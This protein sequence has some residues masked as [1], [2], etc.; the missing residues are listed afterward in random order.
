V[1]PLLAK[2]PNRTDYLRQWIDT[3]SNMA[4]VIVRKGDANRA[5][6]MLRGLVP[7]SR[8]LATLCPRDAECILTESV[9]YSELIDALETTD[10]KAA[11]E[12]ARLQTQADE[13]ADQALPGDAIVERELATAYSQE[14]RMLNAHGELAQA[15]D[16]YLR[17]VA[18]R[19]REL[20]RDPSSV[21]VRRG[22]MITY[23]NLAGNLGS[24]LFPNLGDTAG[25]RKYYTKAVAIARDL[26]NA[27]S[28][29]QLAQYD[30][31][32]AL[33]RYATLDVAREELPGSLASLQ[34]ADGILERVVGTDPEAM[35]RLRP[36]AIAQEYE[37]R[38]LEAL[39][40][41]AEAIA[42]YRASIA[43]TERGLVRAPGDLSFMTQLVAS[44]DPLAV[45]LV[46]TGRQDE[47]IPL[48]QG[49]VERASHVA[50]LPTERT[51]VS[52]TVARAYEGLARAQA[53]AGHWPE[54]K[55]AGE[56]ALQG[57]QQAITA[58]SGRVSR[59][60]VARAESLLAD[61]AAHRR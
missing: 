3:Q 24:P 13:R 44:G 32:N 21:I 19:E 18:L 33:L 35:N 55:A 31:A 54:A 29:N 16:R 49:I 53:S 46:H 10:S 9:L 22:L 50:A 4:R 1:A 61:T 45:L 15:T 5:A 6:T 20:A 28:R 58:G 52:I 42:Q 38:R 39:H 27:D 2:Q 26:A 40:R 60:D 43:T 56:R 11:L 36:L 23:G 17:S 41:P 57:Y 34:E 14:G 12:Y 25:A 59:T 30:L 8:R 7:A 47:G 51:R 37:G 48:A